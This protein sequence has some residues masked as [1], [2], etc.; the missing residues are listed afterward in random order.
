M[1]PTQTREARRKYEDTLL[2]S[3]TQQRRRST[4]PPMALPSF[5]ESWTSLKIQMLTELQRL[6]RER[7]MTL[8]EIRE[9]ML[10]P[11][12]ELTAMEQTWME[13]TRKLVSVMPPLPPPPKGLETYPSTS[14]PLNQEF[15]NPPSTSTPSN[16]LHLPHPNDLIHQIFQTDR[17]PIPNFDS[18][19]PR[20]TKHPSVAMLMVPPS[21][22][23]KLEIVAKPPVTSSHQIS[24]QDSYGTRGS[25]LSRSPSPTPME[26]PSTLTTFI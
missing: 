12:T 5:N 18:R 16:T 21:D 26:L 15:P 8:I 23:M 20:V 13:Q 25:I 22:P 19:S 3:M 9:W 17:F 14:T 6:A 24:H 1:A 11:G 7:R 2:H 10:T 4:I